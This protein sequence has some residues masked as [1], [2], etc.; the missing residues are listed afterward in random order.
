M[1][2]LIELYDKNPIYNY[3][4]SLIFK[5]E[6]VIFVGAVNE[7]IDKCKAKTKKFAGLN[8]LES[9]YEFIYSKPNDFADN[10]QTIKNII[11]KEKANGKNCFIDVTGGKDLAL[12]A[13]GNFMGDGTDIIYLDRKNSR[14]LLLPEGGSLEFDAR[15]SCE[16][17]I[18]IA[19]GTVFEVARNHSYTP[20][21]ENIIKKVIDLFFEYRDEWTRFVKYLQQVSKKENEKYRNLSVDAPLSF[22]N[23]GKTFEYNEKIMRE[24]EK[25]NAIKNLDI[26]RDKKR[27]CFTFASSDLANLLVNEGVWLELKVYYTAKEM[28][29]FYDVNTGVKFIWDIPCENKSLA[30]LLSESV[31]RNEVD[32]VLSRG[33]NPVFVSC[34]TRA[35]FNEDLNELYAIKE[36]FGGDFAKAI[37]VTTKPVD[38]N[39]P[40]YER[41]QALGI[42]I[43]DEKAFINNSLAEKLNILTEGKRK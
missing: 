10:Y 28:P 7:P 17:F 29:C 4:A 9:K 36:K 16:T 24:L 30:N 41:A 39:S 34:K 8:G 40:I 15:I 18:T 43:I 6:K 14:Y 21:E 5:P 42:G 12:V 32:A 37:I 11:S 35:P 26:Q 1:K 23:N 20:E 33:I 22:E 13:A 2:T 31:P 38:R 19:G 25:V 27:L 3:L